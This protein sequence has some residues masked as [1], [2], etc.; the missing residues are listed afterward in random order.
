[1]MAVTIIAGAASIL[2]LVAYNP[3]TLGPTGVTLW[4]VGLF[5]TL[6]GLLT[7][8]FF[9]LK[10]RRAEIMGE[11]K[12]FFSSWRQGLLVAAVAIILL[13]L[14]SLRQ[15]SLRDAVLLAVLALLVEFYGRTRR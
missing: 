7:F 4:F 5:M 8:G 9:R 11:S 2:G 15:L 6:Q 14:S 1:M 10:R 12:R 3:T 13:G